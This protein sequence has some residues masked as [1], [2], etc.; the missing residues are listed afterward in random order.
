MDKDIIKKETPYL[1][2]LLGIFILNLVFGLTKIPYSDELKLLLVS[3]ITLFVYAAIMFY[4]V[5]KY[6]K[7]EYNVYPKVKEITKISVIST[8]ILAAIIFIISYVLSTSDMK[9]MG[10]IY[11]PIFLIVGEI[12]RASCRE[13]V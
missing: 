10:I 5:L 7:P 12:G 8:T 3:T 4:I 6:Q 13:R 11:F 2:V 1:V 9:V